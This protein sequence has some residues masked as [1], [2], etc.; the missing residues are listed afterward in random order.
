MYGSR[1][2]NIK[3]M[4]DQESLSARG[5]NLVRWRTALRVVLCNLEWLPVLIAPLLIVCLAKL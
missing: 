1:D 3:M 2:H 4:L 5:H